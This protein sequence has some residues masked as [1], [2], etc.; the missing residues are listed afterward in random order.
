MT[1]FGLVKY[2]LIGSD[3]VVV[4]SSASLSEDPGS[5]PAN[6]RIYSTM[7]FLI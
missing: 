4:K 3:S 5:N 1:G 6:F 7:S 2:Q